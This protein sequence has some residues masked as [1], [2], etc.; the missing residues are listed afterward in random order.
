MKTYFIF[1]ILCISNPENNQGVSCFNYWEDSKEYTAQ[2]CYERAI[3]VGDQIT[4][5]FR[6]EK[7]NILEHSVWC[8]DRK[9]NI[10]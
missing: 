9:G 7:I 6:Q 5:K 8:I 2:K 10:I 3:V 1:A 4:A